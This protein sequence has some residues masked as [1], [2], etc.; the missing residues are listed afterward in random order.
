MFCGNSWQI[1]YAGEGESRKPDENSSPSFDDST[2]SQV[3]LQ[4]N[5][6]TRAQL[7]CLKGH[8]FMQVKNIFITLINYLPNA[9]SYYIF[10]CG[11]LDNLSHAC[12]V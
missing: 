11:F 2:G 6:D 10:T 4:S 12:L 5:R 1:L 7:I 8:E 9:N 3:S